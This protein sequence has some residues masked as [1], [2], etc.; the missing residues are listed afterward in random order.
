[1]YRNAPKNEDEAQYNII[2]PIVAQI[3]FGNCGPLE[4]ST[5]KMYDARV[6][7]VIKKIEFHHEPEY[8]KV[9]PGKRLSRAE[10]T[11]K[12]GETFRSEA[13]EPDG[14]HNADVSIDDIVKKIYSINGAYSSEKN[15][16]NM[17][18]KIL[19]TDY[20]EPFSDI[21]NAIQK[22]AIE[23]NIPELKHV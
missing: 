7:D 22:C 21:L 14:D 9:F 20:E 8:D 18:S 23:N 12:D 3:L 19:E 4:S 6:E 1:L 15:I 13:F 11:T 16:N 10:I 5:E 2:Y 17:V